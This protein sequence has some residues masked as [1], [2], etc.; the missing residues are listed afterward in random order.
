MGRRELPL[1]PDSGPVA[2]FAH[3]LRGLRALAGNPSYRELARRAHYSASALS[4]AARG[5][6]LPS[7][8]VTRAYV[9][10]CGGDVSEW[11]ERWRA[12]AGRPAGR[13]RLLRPRGSRRARAAAAT[14]AMVCGSALAAAGTTAV[15][16]EPGPGRPVTT[17]AVP[18][19][20]GWSVFWNPEHLTATV[21]SSRALRLRVRAGSGAVG[22]THLSALRPG[23]PVVLRFWY[24][25]QGQG[26]IC[27]FVRDGSGAVRWVPTPP[28]RL[29]PAVPPGWHAYRWTVPA[30]TPRALGVQLDDTGATDFVVLL[31]P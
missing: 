9:Q 18:A 23:D 31:E 12:V 14:A 6:A 15:I 16:V 27:P 28:L 13:R 21:T 24:G 20:V 29:G 5:T 30:V 17:S 2:R 19:G 1:D 10:A 22:T 4:T 3:E 26:E 7:L 25:G 11:E 8:A